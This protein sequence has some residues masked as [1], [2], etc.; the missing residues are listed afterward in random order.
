[1]CRAC[2]NPTAAT[3]SYARDIKRA[4]REGMKKGP[5]WWERPRNRNEDINRLLRSKDP[6][7]LAARVISCTDQD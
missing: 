6:N 5:H 2:D 3:E 4:C 7:H 1:M